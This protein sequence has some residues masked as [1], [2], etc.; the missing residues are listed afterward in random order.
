MIRAGH[1]TDECDAS[2]AEGRCE[3][4]ACR[5]RL[6]NAAIRLGDAIISRIPAGYEDEEGFHAGEP[7]VPVPTRK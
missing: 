3:R 6:V 1:L 5:K 2:C 7:P 4:F